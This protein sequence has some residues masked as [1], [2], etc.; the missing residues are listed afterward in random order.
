MEYSKSNFNIYISEIGKKKLNQ[1]Y[2]LISKLA[3]T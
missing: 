2:T 3:I 1:V